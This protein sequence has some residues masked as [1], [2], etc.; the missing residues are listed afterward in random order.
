MTGWHGVSWS[1]KSSM[2][3]GLCMV[4]LCVQFS[5]ISSLSSVRHHW[6]SLLCVSCCCCWLRSWPDSNQEFCCLLETW[7]GRRNAETNRPTASTPMGSTSSGAGQRRRRRQLRRR[8]EQRRRRL[9]LRIL[10]SASSCS[11]SPSWPAALW[12]AGFVPG[13]RAKKKIES[14]RAACG[15]RK[16]R[17]AF[18]VR[19][20]F[21]IAPPA[22][23]RR[24]TG[25]RLCSKSLAR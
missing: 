19:D 22:T 23:R 6:A 24:P 10:C 15:Q 7:T 17:S 20:C 3:E 11:S 2:I 21:S 1:S 25:L 9:R 18:A 4:V 5:R 12:R 14:Q 8:R 13:E 16:R